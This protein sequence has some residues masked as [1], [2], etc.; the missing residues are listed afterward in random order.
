MPVYNEETGLIAACTEVSDTLI[1][2][3]YDLE[4]IIVDDCSRDGTHQV[5]CRYAES[6]PHVRVM[7]HERNL[8]PC[9]GLATGARAARHPWVLLLPADI[10]IPLEDVDTLWAARLHGDV[11]VGYVG[12]TH[13]RSW[14]RR[15]QSGIYTSIVNVAFGLDLPQVNY[16]T[17]YRRELFDRIQL[18]TEGV[19]RHAEILVRARQLGY[20]F[21]HAPLGYRPREKG[22]ASG[23]KPKV[24]GKT[25]WEIVKLRA[26]LRS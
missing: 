16:V 18:V 23:T 17:L 5:A 25:I 2:L 8:G 13:D 15:I 1:R 19:A 21:A 3:G 26:S 11:V 22:A 4:L 9:S 14:R 7:K 12:K 24:I 6:H 20:R 10:L